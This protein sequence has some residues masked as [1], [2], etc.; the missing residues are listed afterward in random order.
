MASL[1]DIEI[2]T[3]ESKHPRKG[4]LL[5]A[6]KAAGGV[7][8]LASLLPAHEDRRKRG[9]SHQIIYK[10][11]KDGGCPESRSSDIAEVTGVSERRLRGLTS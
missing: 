4:A 5:R 2:Q 7:V 3:I 9:I 6:V 8:K 10:W 11:I 1:S